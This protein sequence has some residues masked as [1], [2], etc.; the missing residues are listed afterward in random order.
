M[1]KD[2]KFDFFAALAAF[3]SKLKN[4]ICLALAAVSAQLLSAEEKARKKRLVRKKQ[5]EEKKNAEKTVLPYNIRKKEPISAGSAVGDDTGEH[6]LI[7]KEKRSRNEYKSRMVRR[8]AGKMLLFT[9]IYVGAIILYITVISTTDFGYELEHTAQRLLKNFNYSFYYLVTDFIGWI[10]L[11]IYLV[12][13]IAIPFRTVSRIAGYVDRIHSAAESVLNKETAVPELPRDVRE[14]GTTLR[15]IKVSITQSEQL[16]KEAEQRK[17]D[18]V[19]YLAHDLKTPLASIIGYLTLLEE[20]PDLPVK[21]RAKYTGITLNK[22]YRLEQLINEFFDITRFNLQSV[23]L[24]KSR[25]DI[26]LMLEQITDEFYPVLEE[27]QLSVITDIEP[28]LRILGDSDKLA[29]VF[30]NLL[31]NAVNY[32]YSE[33]EINISAWRHKSKIAIAV[34]NCGDEI[35]PQTLERLFEKFFRADSSRH[36]ST[37]GS[38]LGLAIAKQIV[39]LHGGKISAVSNSRYTEF[40]IILPVQS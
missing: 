25:V 23:E 35:P 37:G 14:I 7:S 24:E 1:K 15:E 5:R 22:A 33:T 2:V 26:S 9:V 10:L 17:N 27:K 6:E 16:A 39:E 38:G 3:G 8:L 34:R 30:D 31:R 20:S 12:V 29:R 19:V 18:L 13:M 21:Q 32:S 40:R 36:S 11:F 28:H 4:Y